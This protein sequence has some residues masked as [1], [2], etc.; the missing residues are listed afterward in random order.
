MP[1]LTLI[2]AETDHELAELIAPTWVFPIIAAAIFILLT[3]VSW[4][5]RDVWHRHADKVSDAGDGAHH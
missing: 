5:F 4:S 2:P 3:A 1:L